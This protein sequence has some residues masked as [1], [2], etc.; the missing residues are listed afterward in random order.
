MGR[1]EGIGGLGGVEIVLCQYFMSVL[2]K[3]SIILQCF[4]I[5]VRMNKIINNK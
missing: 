4:F 2:S 5:H 1:C 3:G